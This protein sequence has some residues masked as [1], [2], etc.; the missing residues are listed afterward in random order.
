MFLRGIRRGSHGL[1]VV[2][3]LLYAFGLSLRETSGFLWVFSERI[4]K[5][6]VE[7]WVRE[8]EAKLSFDVAPSWHPVIAVDES[9]VKCCGR[10]IYVWV[11][12]DAYTRRPIC[13]VLGSH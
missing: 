9:V 10:P 13:L 7:D 6:S 5:S 3:V 1:K 4:S 2:A 11:A 12:V 8:V